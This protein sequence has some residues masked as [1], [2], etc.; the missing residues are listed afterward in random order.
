MFNFTDKKNEWFGNQ[1]STDVL[2]SAVAHEIWK[3]K[4]LKTAKFSGKGVMVD[5]QGKFVIPSN[6][7]ATISTYADFISRYN[8][9]II[10]PMRD[11]S[12]DKSKIRPGQPVFVAT[13]KAYRQVWFDPKDP[14][15]ILLASLG[16]MFETPEALV[17]WAK[18]WGFTSNIFVSQIKIVEKPSVFIAKYNNGGYQVDTSI[19]NPSID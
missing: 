6:P 14:Q 8:S 9:T 1:V 4:V 18:T 16:L 10:H 7:S 12:W 17:S 13:S 19:G 3:G 2:R 15:H 5:M 11:E